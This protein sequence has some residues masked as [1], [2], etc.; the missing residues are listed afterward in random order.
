MDINNYLTDQD[1]KDWAVLLEPWYWKL[2]DSFD[3]WMVNKLGD[4]ILVLEDDQ[5]YFFDIAL[6][7]MDLIAEDQDDFVEKVNQDDNADHWFAISLVDDCLD[8][9]MCLTADQCFGYK[10]SPILGGEFTANNLEPIDLI[11]HY[12]IHGQIHEQIKGVPEGETVNI[13]IVPSEGMTFNVDDQS[14]D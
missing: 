4:L 11:V 5:I 1:G 9:D 7:S 3:I 6:G 2:P 13:E 8:A 12:S 10:L 14:E